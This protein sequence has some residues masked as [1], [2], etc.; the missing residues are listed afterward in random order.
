MREHAHDAVLAVRLANVQ[1]LECFHFETK[2]CIDEQQRNVADLGQID[3]VVDVVVAF[4]EGKSLVF[5][6]HAGDRTA[7]F[8]D[9]LAA[10]VANQI[11]DQRRLAHFGRT[12]YTDHYRRRF[13]RCAIDLWN[14]ILLL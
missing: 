7:N 11:A 9:V 1:V 8:V 14:V 6:G 4:E 10:E 2:R 13:D 3:H 5:A 12:D